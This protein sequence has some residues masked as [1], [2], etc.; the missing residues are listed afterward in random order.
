MHM[1]GQKKN[2]SQPGVERERGWRSVSSLRLTIRQHLE[3]VS[4]VLNPRYQPEFIHAGAN[5]LGSE[6]EI[7]ES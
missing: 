7:N 2:I 6:T 3:A 5:K 4:V 1:V